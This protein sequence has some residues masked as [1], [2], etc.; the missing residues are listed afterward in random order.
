M[1]RAKGDQTELIHM[2]IWCFSW[3]TATYCWFFHAVAQF[4][5]NLFRIQEI[6]LLSSVHYPINTDLSELSILG[7]SWTYILSIGQFNLGINLRHSPVI[8]VINVSKIVRV[9]ETG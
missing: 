4:L 1:R 8:R 9:T 5:F 3:R 2:L 7:A 6:L